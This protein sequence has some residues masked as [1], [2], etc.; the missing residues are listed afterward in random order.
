MPRGCWRDRFDH[1]L[2]HVVFEPG[3]RPVFRLKVGRFHSG[4]AA[5]E[6]R[7]RDGRTQ[8][9]ESLGAGRADVLG[10]A[11][12][13]HVGDPARAALASSARHAL[14]LVPAQEIGRHLAQVLADPP[15][16]LGPE[17]LPFGVF[18]GGRDISR[19]RCSRC[20]V[21]PTRSSRS[22]CFA[23][24][25]MSRPSRP[26]S[27]RTVSSMIGP[28]RWGRRSIRS[29]PCRSPARLEGTLRSGRMA[30]VRRGQARF[31]SEW[32][33]D[34][35][36]GNIRPRRL[37]RPSM[38]NAILHRLAAL[39]APKDVPKLG[40]NE[41]ATA[42]AD[43]STRSAA[44]RRTRAVFGRNGRRGRWPRG[45]PPARAGRPQPCW[46]P[47]RQRRSCATCPPGQPRSGEDAVRPGRRS[48]RLTRDELVAEVRRF[49]PASASIA[50][51]RR[52][53][54]AGTI[55]SFGACCR[56]RSSPRSPVPPWPNFLRGCLK[57]RE[58]LDRELP[59]AP[60]A[61]VEYE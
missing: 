22:T 1:Q 35:G 34:P 58:S 49:A 52:R 24:P 36:S 10:R 30:P 17:A 21:P 7:G 47:A 43:A 25:T 57:Y 53:S 51:A 3:G 27:P 14:S 56:R 6:P 23:P 50:T 31:R 55:R 33:P 54:C 15:P 19:V 9:R 40:R 29:A 5:P 38:L 42:V 44:S 59:N 39:F 12:P 18:P 16:T 20:R 8:L 13:A 41:P 37:G 46:L 32:H 60:V 48:G 2:G 26:W 28:E 61:D 11:Q 45:A 4:G